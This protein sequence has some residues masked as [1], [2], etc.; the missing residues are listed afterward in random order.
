[1]GRAA[2]FNVTELP[3]DRAMAIA[4][5]LIRSGRA[6]GVKSH[7]GYLRLPTENNFFYWISFHGD[8]LLRG[9]RRESATEL[10]RGFIDA[11]VRAGEDGTDPGPVFPSDTH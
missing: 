5:G 11:M 8:R 7:S 1:M 9:E 3:S 10:Q 6:S 4:R 2:T